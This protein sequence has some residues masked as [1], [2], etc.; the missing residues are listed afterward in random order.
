MEAAG[1]GWW[2]PFMRRVLMSDGD[3]ELRL[4]DGVCLRVGGVTCLWFY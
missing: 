4:V 3:R 2:H 1:G